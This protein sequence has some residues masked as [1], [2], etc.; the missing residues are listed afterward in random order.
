MKA[1]KAFEKDW[2]CKGFQYEIGKTYTHGGPIKLCQSGFHACEAPLDVL[3]YYPLDSQFAEV[4][5]G[6]VSDEKQKDTKR[7]GKSITV[8]AALNIASMISAQVEWT[9]ANADNKNKSSGH[10]STIEIVRIETG[11]KPGFEQELKKIVM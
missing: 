3:D 9:I 8:K 6:D 5:L 10:S 11:I 1:Y 2:T 7:V 4:D